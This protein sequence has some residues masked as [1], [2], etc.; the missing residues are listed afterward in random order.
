[1]SADAGVAVARPR[2][3]FE[4]EHAAP[5]AAARQRA[6]RFVD[7][8][9]EVLAE[10]GNFERARVLLARRAAAGSADADV[11]LDAIRV[12]RSAAP[13]GAAWQA[14]ASRALAHGVEIAGA[15]AALVPRRELCAY[16]I[17]QDVGWALLSPQRDRVAARALL[18]LRL[19]QQLRDDPVL[20]LAAI[21]DSAL[22]SA[23]A[24]DAALRALVIGVIA[25]AVW[26]ARDSALA[27]ARSYAI[28]ETATSCAADVQDG[29]E[30]EARRAWTNALRLEPM[31]T[32]AKTIVSAG[33]DGRRRYREDATD[34][35]PIPG[36]LARVMRSAP[37]ASRGVSAQLARELLNDLRV[38]PDAY[39]EWTDAIARHAPELGAWLT[40]VCG[41][42][43]DVLVAGRETTI[44]TTA[45]ENALSAA[46]TGLRKHRLQ[47]A[48]VGALLL[49]TT[50]LIA[51]WPWSDL[52]RA[53]IAVFAL[54][55]PWPLR[56]TLDRRLYARVLRPALLDAIIRHGVSLAALCR[57]LHAREIVR[58]QALVTHAERDRGLGLASALGAFAHTEI[59]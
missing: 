54:L 11:Y 55:G 36:A 59:T 46:G 16:L 14:W 10:Q 53:G 29:A 17:G 51:T 43:R 23:A 37:L 35:T 21:D 22:R 30:A 18:S 48:W 40:E 13:A 44:D 58:R 56:R 47:T 42:G 2:R 41:A 26:D 5:D 52:A 8:E 7:V 27:I 25:G 31:W 49:S 4:P 19:E 50:L 38:R 12:E 34:P 3:P 6:E 45:V 33:D 39:L 9:L 24:D 28:D 15:L 57:A 1:V 20:A 32:A